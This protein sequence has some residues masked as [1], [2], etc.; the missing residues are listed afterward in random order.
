LKTIY[1][2][3]QKSET[4]KQ[5]INPLDMLRPTLF[6]PS[7]AYKL[8][9]KSLAGVGWQIAT[10]TKL[11][12]RFRVPAIAGTS[13]SYLQKWLLDVAQAAVRRGMADF[14]GLGHRMLSFPQLADDVLAG[15]KMQRK[16]F[17]RSFSDCT[18]APRSGLVSG[19]YPL[20]DFYK[21][22]P[23]ATKLAEAKK[24]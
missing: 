16:L 7:D 12:A 3:T 10:T 1:L 6:P 23:E 17:C 9:G 2:V 4:M 20:D 24:G 5:N 19:C 21:Q 11:K 18:T 8:P 14:I 13:Y 22:L 15:C